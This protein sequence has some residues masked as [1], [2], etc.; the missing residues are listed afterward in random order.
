MTITTRHRSR[1][2]GGWRMSPQPRLTEPRWRAATCTCFPR[3][4]ML[5]NHPI[6][7][8]RTAVPIKETIIEPMQPSRLEKNANIIADVKRRRKLKSRN[9]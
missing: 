5:Y 8:N 3:H 9:G 6:S 1:W 2:D 7:K 4:C